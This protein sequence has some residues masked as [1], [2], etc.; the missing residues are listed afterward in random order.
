VHQAHLAVLELKERPV[1]LDARDRAFD[2]RADL[3]LCDLDTPSRGRPSVRAKAASVREPSRSVNGQPDPGWHRPME[4]R[5]YAEPSALLAD[6]RP[7]LL[8][9]PARNNL[10]LAILQTL[11]DQPAVYPLFRLWPGEH[12]G[13][14]VGLAMQTEPF[15]V[16]RAEPARENAVDQLADAVL[17]DGGSLPGVRANRPWGERFAQRI[18]T[19]TGLHVAQVLREGVWN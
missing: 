13:V 19:R 7:L 15:N 9:Q 4:V 5:R 17:D 14:P 6:A 11:I 18:H 8:A 1:L 16:L 10:P 12:E 3:D 2:R